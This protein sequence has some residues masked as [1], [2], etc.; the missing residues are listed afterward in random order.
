MAFA[1]AQNADTGYG[2]KNLVRVRESFLP[3]VTSAVHTRTA[4]REILFTPTS[5]VAGHYYSP[6]LREASNRVLS[7]FHGRVEAAIAR[8][9]IKSHVEAELDSKNEF[10]I[11]RSKTPRGNEIL[12][13]L[14]GWRF[15][16]RVR[17][18]VGSEKFEAWKNHVLKTL[19][20]LHPDDFSPERERDQP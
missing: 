18:R 4:P 17:E 15:G 6:Q 9:R 1:K 11:L 16:E 19:K 2:M 10:V 3:L 8:D 12:E 5:A 7:D 20:P 13:S 14:F